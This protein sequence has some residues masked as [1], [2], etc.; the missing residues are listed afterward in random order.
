MGRT[1]TID[2]QAIRDSRDEIINLNQTIAISN[3]KADIANKRMFWLTISI[4]VLT[5]FIAILTLI[6]AWEDI[7]AIVS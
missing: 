7:K 2:N 6:M 4:T 5:I 1:A 3:E